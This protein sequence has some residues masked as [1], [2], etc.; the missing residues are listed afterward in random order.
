MPK[1]LKIGLPLL[2]I[3]GLLAF[4]FMTPKGPL[5][6]HSAPT[7]ITINAGSLYAA[8]ESD[9]TAA[10]GTY[11][12]KVLEVSG[13]LSA[14]TQDDAGNYVMNLT[15]DS[16]MGQVVCNL[17]PNEPRPATDTAIGQMITIKGVCTGYLFDVVLDNATI[18]SQ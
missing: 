1:I 12:G 10:N 2:I 6:I 11:A 4:K 3:G 18:I 8:F 7:E 16:P 17:S 9:E 14:I 13:A 5:D 15:A